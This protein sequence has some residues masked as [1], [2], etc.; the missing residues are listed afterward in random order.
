[1]LSGRAGLPGR[2]RSGKVLEKSAEAIVVRAVG[3]AIEALRSRKAEQQIGR[4]GNDGRRAESSIARTRLDDSMGVERQQGMGD[5]LYLWGE[6]APVRPGASSKGG[7]RASA[8]EEQQASTASAQERALA[9]NLMEEVCERENLIQAYKR[10]KSNKGSPGVDGLSVHDLGPWL[11]EHKEALIASLLDGHYEPQPVKGVEIP[12]PGG[13][14]RQLGIPTVRDRLVQQA[15]LQVL[16]PLLDPTF[17]E[18]SYGFRPRRSAHQ[19]LHQASEYVK[20]GRGIVVDID[21][22]KFFDRVNHDILMSRLARRVGDKRLL[23]II[24]RFLEAGMM[25]NGVCIERHEGT[26]QGGPLS[27]L[28]ANLLLDDLDRELE[29]RGHTFCRYADDCN[30]YVRSKAA[31]ESV[32]SSVTTFVEKRL[33]LRVNRDKSAVAHVSERKFLGYRLLPGGKLGIAPKSLARAK[34]RVRQI[35]RR[36]RGISLERM[37]GELNS[38]LTGWVTYFRYAECKSHLQRLEEWIRRKLRCVRL[39]QRKRAKSI[40][41]FLRKLGVPEWRAWCLASSGKGWWRMAGSPQ[42]AEGMTLAWF[43]EQG[44]VC[45]TERYA[46]LQR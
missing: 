9:S 19:A 14:M 16:E 3:E 13:G 34:D 2:R 10:V 6:L 41:D 32:M 37:I 22:E 20:E 38:F 7:T 39:K 44:L 46:T 11:A 45:L 18:S 4:P 29:K 24:R 30:I 1:V 33:R 23:R 5:Q 21:L 27:P 17:S 36:N 43:R 42:A 28:L 35:T 40:A 31:G 15:I 8:C 25:C 12:K 26:P